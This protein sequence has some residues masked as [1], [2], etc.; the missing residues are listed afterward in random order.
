MTRYA[1]GYGVFCIEAIP[2]QPQLAHCHSFFV[3]ADQRGKGYGKKLKQEQCRVLA[4]LGFD[5]ATCTTAGDNTRQHRVLESCGWQ[6]L[7][8]FP[9]SKTGGTTVLWGWTVTDQQAAK[10]PA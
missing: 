1:T 7:S 3:K 10:G 8:E 2:N 9:N 4:E 5:Y 6:R